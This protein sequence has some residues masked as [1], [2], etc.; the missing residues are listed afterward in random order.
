MFMRSLCI[1]VFIVC[2]AL[3]GFAQTLPRKAMFGVTARAVD[4]G[5]AAASGLAKGEGLLV[6]AVVPDSTF[7]SIG[8]KPGDL[9]LSIDNKPINSPEA[10]IT[11]AQTFTEGDRIIVGLISEGKRVTR[12]ATARPRPKETSEFGEP[13]YDAVSIGSG[14]LRTITHVPKNRTGK[15]PA[16]MYIQGFPCTSQEFAPNSTNAIKR[17]IDDWVKAG[18]AVFRVERPNMGDSR[19][20]KDCRDINF[21]E[22][23]EVNIAGYKKLMAYDFVD[24]SNVFFFGHSM[25]SVTAPYLAQVLQPKGIIVYGVVLRSWFEYFV[26]LHRIQPTY[27]GASRVEAEARSRELLPLYFEWLENGKSPAELKQNPK[28]KA[29]LDGPNELNNSGDYFHGRHYKFW[30][31]MNQRRLGEAWSKVKCPVLAIYGEFDVQALNSQGAQEIAAA[32]NE[33]NPGKGEFML[34]PGVEHV[35]T[36]AS[37]YREV[38]GIIA[39]G[40]LGQ[41]MNENYHPVIGQKTIEWYDRVRNSK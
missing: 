4:E 32:V 39:S 29:I 7:A 34:I 9:I 28:F 10:L 5:T 31:T 1:A 13:V 17:A 18:Y 33:A 37:S 19:N 20:T 2:S 6:S 15:V 11:S 41:H 36:K 12:E 3:P 38:G 40:K 25:G 14:T 8:V 22:E 35:F 30:Y 21:D 27:F 26:D 23:L 16:I 24:T